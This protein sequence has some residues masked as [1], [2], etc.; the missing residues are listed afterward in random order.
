MEKL[1]AKPKNSRLIPGFIM[2]ISAG[3][4]AYYVS[5]ISVYVNQHDG[6]TPYEEGQLGYITWYLVNGR[7]PDFDV[8]EVDQF[9]HPPLHYASSAGL[10]R[11][12]WNNFPAMK[13]NFEPLQILPYI[14]TTVTIYLIW[15]ILLLFVGEMAEEYWL[16][17]VLAFVAFQ[18]GL[19]IRS[20]SI[21][22]DALILMMTILTLY[23]ALLWYDEGKWWQIFAIALSMGLALMTKKSAALLVVPLAI[24]GIGRL[25]EQIK[26][27]DMQ[28]VRTILYQAGVF[29]CIAAPIGLWWYLRNLIVYGVPLNFFWNIE[30][31]W[32]YDEYLGN[33][34]MAHRLFTFD[35]KSFAYT[36]TYLQYKTAGLQDYN[37]LVALLKTAVSDVWS[38][39]YAD[40]GLKQLSYMMLITRTVL[41]I[42]GTVSIPSFVLGSRGIIFDRLHDGLQRW[43][44]VALFIAQ[45]VSYYFFC[46]DYP[47]VWTMDYRYIEAIIVCDGLFLAAGIARWNKYKGIVITVK[48]MIIFFCALVSVF[49]ILAAVR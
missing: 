19:V 9:W 3:I 32:E 33:I 31:G 10:L 4:R 41:V 12:V 5:Y 7:M 20:A 26:R 42:I 30:K 16:Y 38:W 23:M 40:E 44:I 25:Y 18:P 17:F 29:L 47:Y 34:P 43:S 35:I 45:I 24:L 28:Q 14:Y 6:G 8:S 22:N 1:M 11:L 48:A 39:S 37:P 2:L 15:K 46:F 49:F 21:N 13:G 36:N 27:K